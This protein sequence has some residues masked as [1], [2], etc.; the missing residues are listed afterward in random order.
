VDY[1]W[2]AHGELS[3]GLRERI[4]SAFLE[5]D[6]ANPVHRRLLDLHRTQRYIRA[7]DEDW[8]VIEEAA[9]AAGLLK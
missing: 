5:L 8:K 4:R 1:V 3:A 2:T 7:H 9:V 6:Y